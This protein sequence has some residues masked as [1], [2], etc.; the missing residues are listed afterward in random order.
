M[1]QANVK[2]SVL[3]LAQRKLSAG[4][5]HFQW[6]FKDEEEDRRIAAISLRS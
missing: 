5:Y 3:C 2:S 6:I 4:R 1:K